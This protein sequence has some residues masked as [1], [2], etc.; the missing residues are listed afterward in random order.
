MASHP[1]LLK[2]VDPSPVGWRVGRSGDLGRRSAAGLLLITLLSAGFSDPGILLAADTVTVGG[3]AV[4]MKSSELFQGDK[5]WT[6]HLTFAPDQWS[7]LEPKGGGG[8]LGGG[9]GP[10]GA[11]GPG[12]PGGGG[13]RG[14]GP[15][16]FGPGTFVAPGFLKAGDKDG[17]KR[18]SR[19]EFRAMAGE[20]FDDWD[21]HKSGSVGREEVSAG[22][23]RTLP[24]PDFGGR[25]GG[26][27]G[28]RAGVPPLVGAEG[29]RNGLASAAGIE[30]EQVHADLDLEGTVLKDV[31]VRYKGNGTWMGSMNTRKRSFKIDLNK[32][33]KGQKLAGVTKLN[34]HNC[35]TDPSCMNEVLSHRL[36]RDAGV[37]APR[38]AYA[39]VYVTVPGKFN[40]D[41]FGLYSLVEDVDKN[42]AHENFSS[43]KGAI[44]KPV[45]PEPFS[46]LGDDWARYKQVYDAKTDLADDQTRRVIEFSRLVT[47]ASDEEFARHAGD[48]LDLDEFARFMAVTVWISTMDSILGPGQNYYLHLHPTSNRFQFIPWDLDHGFGQFGLMGSQEQRDNLSLDKPWRGSNRFLERVFKLESF[49]ARYRARLE[50]Y[51]SGICRPERLAAQVDELARVIRPAIAAESEEA[52]KSF[53]TVVAGS[54]LNRGAFGPPGEPGGRRGGPPGGFGQPVKPIKAF[55]KARVQSVADQLAGKSKGEQIAEFGFGPER[56]GGPGGPAGFLADGFLRALDAN[57]DGKLTRQEFAAGFEKWFQSWSRDGKG[58]VT[59][60]ELRDGLNQELSPFRGGPPRPPE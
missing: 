15:G 60:E 2:A 6:L 30:F 23:G 16:G 5:I 58:P 32:Y 9:G 56:R 25:G 40:R 34:L 19:E 1:S 36:F 53:D 11:R 54:V 24:P 42:F 43:R 13:G 27:G 44:F 7:A 26:P 51:N 28:G 48:Y 17:D 18:L 39:R 49:R 47:K 52:A 22:L 10:G 21:T 46:D 12:G 38:T 55:V 29:K 45:T 3:G 59:E 4:S 57:Q 14:R 31:A 41:Y 20:W 35:I 50:E 37:P 8:F 33:T